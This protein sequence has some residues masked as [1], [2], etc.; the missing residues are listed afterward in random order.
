MCAVLPHAVHWWQGAGQDRDVRGERQRHGRPRL[1]KVHAAS[2][3]GIE[4]WCQPPPDTIGAERIDGDEQQVG[5]R[6]AARS[7]VGGIFSAPNDRRRQEG[8]E[9]RHSERTLN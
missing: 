1:G 3:E 7:P 2:R 5:S 8:E 6:A 4:R 9:S